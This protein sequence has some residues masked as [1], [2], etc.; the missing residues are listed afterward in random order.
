MAS[1]IGK[2]YHPLFYSALPHTVVCGRA[3]LEQRVWINI[4]KIFFVLIVDIL[5]DRAQVLFTRCAHANC[6]VPALAVIG[7]C[8][9]HR[10]A[11][12]LNFSLDWFP[13]VFSPLSYLFKLYSLYEFPLPPPPTHP[14]NLFLEFDREKESSRNFSLHKKAFA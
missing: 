14:S 7:L 2:F 8:D 10:A 5:L 1:F 12:T 13:F 11:Q 9:L 4:M 3:L 6:D